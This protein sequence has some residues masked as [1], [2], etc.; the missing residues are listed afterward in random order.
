M[1]AS[2]GRVLVRDFVGGIQRWLTGK[3]I[4]EALEVHARNGTGFGGFRWSCGPFRVFAAGF[5]GQVP[6]PAKV[7]TVDPAGNVTVLPFLPGGLLYGSKAALGGGGRVEDGLSRW[8][9]HFIPFQHWSHTASRHS[10][11]IAAVGLPHFAHGTFLSRSNGWANK[12]PLGL[13]QS[14]NPAGTDLNCSEW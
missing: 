1:N 8:A 4:L 5:C 2:S 6:V 12:L 7:A 3:E 9:D 13:T 14:S 10:Q 11:M